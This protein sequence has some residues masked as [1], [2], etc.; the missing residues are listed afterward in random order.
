M[1]GHK[2]TATQPSSQPDEMVRLRD[3]L[4]RMKAACALCQQKVD[5]LRESE[6][7]YRVL[8]DESSDP[9][10]SI[11]PDGEYVYVNRAFAEG[12]GRRQEE[13]IGHRIWDVFPPE[14]AEKRFSVARWV[15]ENGEIKVFEVRVPRPDQD[16]YYITTVKPHFNEQAE[17]VWVICISKEITER[18]R[19]ERDLL[20]LST[21]DLLTGLYNRNF[22][23]VEMERIEHSR[24]Y[25]VSIVVADMDNLKAVNDREGHNAGDCLIRKVADILRQSFRAEDIIARIGGD[26]FAVLL[27]QTHET[28]AR[29]IVDRLVQKLA[30]DRV[31]PLRLSIGLASSEAG[32]VL[33]DVMR[34]ADDRMYQEKTLRKLKTADQN[35]EIS[36]PIV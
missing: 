8:L 1:A 11:Q 2:K 32:Q 26:E 29:A 9:I 27:P 30:L 21:H 33:Q 15:F 25:P 13:I 24:L 28:D 20:H 14:E 7:K 12:V 31:Q 4:A 35:A 10:F 6:E 22:Y 5:G 3:E 17:V 23:E 34:L 16:R 36:P 18:K 19:M